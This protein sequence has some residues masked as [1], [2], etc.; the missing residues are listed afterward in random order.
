V[1]QLATD[2]SGCVQLF[3]AGV[4]VPTP[5]LVGREETLRRWTAWLAGGQSI[6]VASPR[7]LGKSSVAH[8]ALRRLVAGGLTAFAFDCSAFEREDAFAR[9]LAEDLLER[10]TG[11]RGVVDRFARMLRGLEPSLSVSDHAA[12]VALRLAK[13]KPGTATVT[14]VLADLAQ[15]AARSGTRHVLLLDEF[16]EVA[17][18]SPTTLGRF[19]AGL[20]HAGSVTA[21]FLGSQAHT[22]RTLFSEPGQ[23]F[24]GFAQP[25]HLDRVMPE[26]W[27]AY[28][29]R[30]SG[31]T[32]VTVHA[33]EAGQ[34]VAMTGGHPYETMRVAN[35]VVLRALL[36]GAAT[37]SMQDVRLG[38]EETLAE[39][40]DLWAER[41][42]AAAR[43]HA[44]QNVLRRIAL[45]EGPYQGH[46]ARSA[47]I[48]RSLAWLEDEG[49]LVHVDKGKWQFVEPMFAEYV[50]RLHR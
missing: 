45:G 23:I 16:Q 36:R 40:S 33:S 27:V 47:V 19:R 46:R 2:W 3:P 4:V 29:A 7:R 49:W 14:E 1:D 6:V 41:W 42:R 18:W 30:R 35:H 38:Y 50:R 11:I 10:E 24:Y 26:E 43:R 21:V 9:A 17:R 5:D 31:R 32:G 20:Q 12:E 25:E 37:A 13:A 48:G 34:L 8:E 39:T 28:L 15:M 22:L 44:A